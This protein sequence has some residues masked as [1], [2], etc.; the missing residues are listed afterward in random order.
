A[1]FN[2]DLDPGSAFCAGVDRNQNGTLGNVTRTFLNNGRF[3]TS[4]IDVQLDWAVPVGPGRLSL[5]SVLNYLIDMKAAELPTDP[6]VEYAGSQGPSN[7]GLDGSSYRWKLLSN[8]GYSFGPASIGLQWRHLP[9]IRSQT[10]VL[11][12]DT[13]ATGVTESYDL[14]SLQ[15][16]YDITENATLRFGIENLFNTEPPLSGRNP[17]AV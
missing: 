15:A 13:T 16:G 10:S 6:L 8:L 9:T 12:P 2:S 1:A 11:V 14:F 17:G 3:K 4:G 7:N 5:N